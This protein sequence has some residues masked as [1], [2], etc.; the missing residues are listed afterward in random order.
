MR[1]SS[2][3]LER[4]KKFVAI[5]TKMETTTTVPLIIDGEDVVLPSRE[6][7][8][9]IPDIESSPSTFF[10]GA[11]KELAIKAVESSARAFTIWS[12]TTPVKRRELLL[13]LA[14]VRAP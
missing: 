9:A 12:K 3:A 11:T 5:I 13:K 10:Q 2:E 7:W 1:T 4:N 14:E 6:R 8:M